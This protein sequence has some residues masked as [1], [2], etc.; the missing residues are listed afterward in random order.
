M[1]SLIL[2]ICIGLACILSSIFF[3]CTYRNI[4]TYNDSDVTEMNRTRR[5][6]NT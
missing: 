5:I 4:H 2:F 3:Y 6:S 1:D